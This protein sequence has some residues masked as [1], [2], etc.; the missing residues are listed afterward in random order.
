MVANE[1]QNKTKCQ[2]DQV[3]QTGMKPINDDFLNS[4]NRFGQ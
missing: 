3:S 1:L 2:S 4:F